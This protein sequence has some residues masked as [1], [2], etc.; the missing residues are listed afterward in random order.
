LGVVSMTGYGR[1]S[2]RRGALLAEAEARSVN[3]R[4]LAVRCRVPGELTRLEP[5]L[6]ALVRKS[7][8]RGTVDVS[9]RVRADRVARAPRI[10]K[11]ALAIYRSALSGLGGGDPALLLTLPGVVST[12]A[13]EPSEA[14]VDRLALEAARA[15]IGKLA[16][17]RAAE[18]RRLRTALARELTALR[19]VVA[20]V[21]KLLPAAVAGQHQQL[22]RRL[23][24][25]LDGRPIAADDPTLLRELAL[26]ADRS[27]VTEEL[28]R[29]QSHLAALAVALDA[30]EPV[31]RRLDFLLQEVGREINTLGSKCSDVRITA[32]VVAAKTAAERLRE[33][34]ANIE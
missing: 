11:R 1:A 28:D 20:A 17:A 22:A 16:E 27:D 6:E 3:G 4:F 30:R 18:G 8:Q 12:A 32:Q 5:R 21:R 34:A 24:A 9:V 33:Q 26:L 2:A 25:L 19:R 7:V 14:A 15:A 13:P 10:D 23:S 29:L 31:G